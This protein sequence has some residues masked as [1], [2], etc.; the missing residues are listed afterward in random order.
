VNVISVLGFSWLRRNPFLHR[1]GRF[2][3]D[4]YPAPASQHHPLPDPR[5][6][7]RLRGL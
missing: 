5:S 7:A 2:S 3:V 1:V 6:S 4:A